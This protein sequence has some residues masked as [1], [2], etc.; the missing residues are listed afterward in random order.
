MLIQKIDLLGAAVFVAVMSLLPLLF[1]NS[2]ITGILTVSVI[3]AIW[4]VSWKSTK[5]S[6]CL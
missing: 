4:A 2:Y 3:Y 5:Q 6:G 1:S